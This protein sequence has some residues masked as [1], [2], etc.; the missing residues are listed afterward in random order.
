MGLDATIN[1]GLTGAKLSLTAWTELL[2]FIAMLEAAAG[3]FLGPVEDSE[4]W[5]KLLLNS[6]A[7]LFGGAAAMLN[8]WLGGVG[9][10]LFPSG[11]IGQVLKSLK[12]LLPVIG[13]ALELMFDSGRSDSGTCTV[14]K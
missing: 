5:V 8:E 4:A 14:R 2:D 7:N 1:G 10:G 3:P 12:G 13:K 9:G 6:S 11:L